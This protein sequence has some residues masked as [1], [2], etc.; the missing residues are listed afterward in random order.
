VGISANRSSY[1]RNF[2]HSHRSPGLAAIVNILRILSL[3][4]RP[5]PSSLSEFFYT[6]LAPLFRLMPPDSTA[7][8]RIERS[9]WLTRER[10]DYCRRLGGMCPPWL[11]HNEGD[12][13]NDNPVPSVTTT[14]TIRNQLL[15]SAP[16]GVGS[17][18]ILATL[19]LPLRFRSHIIF[20]TGNGRRG[21]PPPGS[22]RYRTFTLDRPAPSLV[23]RS[24]R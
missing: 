19:S 17:A 23:L 13:G 2:L 5:D 10:H 15:G 14:Q 8:K 24:T 7:A 11:G 12:V 22:S 21:R 20:A 3:N 16:H 4:R 9:H 1:C 6:L 18:R